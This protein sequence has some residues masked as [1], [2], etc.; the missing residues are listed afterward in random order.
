MII[1]VFLIIALMIGGGINSYLETYAKEKHADEACAYYLKRIK[2]E[3]EPLSGN[4]LEVPES[5]LTYAKDYLPLLYPKWEQIRTNYTRISGEI[6]LMEARYDN[7]VILNNLNKKPI[8]VERPK[9]YQEWLN[10]QNKELEAFKKAHGQIKQAVEKYYAEAQIRGVDS[11]AEMQSMVG[12]IVE[13]A[14]I[15]LEEHGY[16]VKDAPEVATSKDSL[17]K[18]SNQASNKATD[19]SSAS[20]SKQKKA[21]SSNEKAKEAQTKKPKQDGSGKEGISARQKEINAYMK[22]ANA[23]SRKIQQLAGT[24]NSVCSQDDARRLEGN[25]ISLTNELIPLREQ[26]NNF[27]FEHVKDFNAEVVAKESGTFS[28]IGTAAQQASSRLQLLEQS[29]WLSRKAMQNLRTALKN[30]KRNDYE[31]VESRT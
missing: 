27:Q 11:D 12:G 13:S 1:V 7:L 5:V 24:L 29:R 19:A 2:L 30:K 20:T 9:V 18:K 23:Y 6:K 25:L 3:K 8:K 28:S 10:K 15:V 16:E 14:N 17:K 31:W 22:L 26:C 21:A 4:S